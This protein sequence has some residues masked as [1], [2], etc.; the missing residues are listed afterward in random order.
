MARG[1]GQDDS[2]VGPA[3]RW[4]KRQF[5]FH[6]APHQGWGD[7]QES[8]AIEPE[9]EERVREEVWRTVYGRRLGAGS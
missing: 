5:R 3:K 6:G 9:M 8:A 7:R 2:L 1:G 4:M